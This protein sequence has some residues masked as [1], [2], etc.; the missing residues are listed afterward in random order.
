MRFDHRTTTGGEFKRVHRAC[1]MPGTKSS[2]AV[3][4]DLPYWISGLMLDLAKNTRPL[5]P[6][7]AH[8]ARRIWNKASRRIKRSMLF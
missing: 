2:Y 5:D 8:A 7:V 3:E 1:R 6:L 4:G